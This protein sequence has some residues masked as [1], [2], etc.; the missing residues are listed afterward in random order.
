MTSS[1]AEPTSCC[2]VP[3][4]YCARVDAVFNVPGVHVDVG[5]RDDR[6][7]VV[8]E[9]GPAAMQCARCGW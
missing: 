7:Q 1:M 9:T 6:L 5:W 3:G 4:T 2:A 8:V